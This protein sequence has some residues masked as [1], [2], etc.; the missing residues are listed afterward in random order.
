[1]TNPNR[2]FGTSKS[3]EEDVAWFIGFNLG[4]TAINMPDEMSP[5]DYILSK[6]VNGL[7]VATA[8][9]EFRHRPSTLMGDYQT[10][11]I[12]KSKI[13]KLRAWGHEMKIPPILLVLWQDTG[14]MWCKVRGG[15]KQVEQR[16][17]EEERTADRP[18]ILYEIPTSS[19][20]L[21]MEY[22]VKP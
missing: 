9:A 10:L 14:V 22:T 8:I 1:M 17:N 15:Y 11:T 2:D 5:F 12:N 6:R 19:F 4:R 7:E 16:R 3:V 13:D 18:E 21:L 20:K